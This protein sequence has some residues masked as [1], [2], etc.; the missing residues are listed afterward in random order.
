VDES[1]T[2]L[3][4]LPAACTLGASDGAAQVARWRQL[5][6]G[7]LTHRVRQDEELLLVYRADEV[8]RVELESL[9]RVER[10][11]CAFLDWQIEE[12]AGEL[13]LRIRGAAADLDTLDLH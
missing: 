11:C 4:L 10:S 7:S 5:D 13:R 3:P 1:R 12:R 6:A 9:V 8:T 2:E